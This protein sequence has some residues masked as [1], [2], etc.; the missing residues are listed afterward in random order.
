MWHSCCFSFIYG[1]LPVRPVTRSV[2]KAEL[3]IPHAIEGMRWSHRVQRQRESSDLTLLSV[4]STRHESRRCR[5]RGLFRDA[6]AVRITRINIAFTDFGSLLTHRGAVR[7]S[8]F[9]AAAW[10][11]RTACCLANHVM[12]NYS[13]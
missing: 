7:H 9:S 1:L 8:L 4:A 12:V 2:T 10:I 5:D 6:N 3:N 11:T 13:R